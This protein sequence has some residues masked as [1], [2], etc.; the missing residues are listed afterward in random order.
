MDSSLHSSCQIGISTQDPNSGFQLEIPSPQNSLPPD[1]L[2]PDSLNERLSFRVI[3]NARQERS[4]PSVL[5]QKSNLFRNAF[6]SL[7][8]LTPFSLRRLG[9]SFCA[10]D[11]GYNTLA[12]LW[13][14]TLWI[15][16]GDLADSRLISN[17]LDTR[18]H[19]RDSGE[20][21]S[22]A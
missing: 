15:F 17:A 13:I 6:H 4:L 18:N 10:L 14:D 22:D 2:P 9:S 20:D 1:S 5:D 11:T 8:T 3:N 21:S 12:T 19:W 16:S 7:S